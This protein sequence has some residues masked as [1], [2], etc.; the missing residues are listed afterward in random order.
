MWFFGGRLAAA[1]S[2]AVSAQAQAN[3]V[4]AV[5]FNTSNNLTDANRVLHHSNRSIKSTKPLFI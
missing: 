3:F 2:S 1:G 4:Y 5:D